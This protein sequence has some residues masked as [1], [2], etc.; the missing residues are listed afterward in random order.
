[1]EKHDQS[2]VLASE[3]IEPAKK[4][5]RSPKLVEYGNIVAVT[6]AMMAGSFTDGNGKLMMMP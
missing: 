5:Y 6:Q 2:N 3:T 1:M 4:A